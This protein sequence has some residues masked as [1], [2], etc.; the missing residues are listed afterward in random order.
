M[1]RWKKKLGLE[2]WKIYVQ[3]YREGIENNAGA[4]FMTAATAESSWRYMEGN[5]HFS[6]P[7]IHGH[8]DSI[9]ELVIHEL[10]HMVVDEMATEELL[11]HEERVVSHLTGVLA[12]AWGLR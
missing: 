3:V 12:E 7:A 10:L 4:G 8:T 11:E 1:K 2:R 9:D 6:A 5:I